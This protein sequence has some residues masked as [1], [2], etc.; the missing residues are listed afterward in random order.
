MRKVCRKI[1]LT[2]FWQRSNKITKVL[3]HEFQKSITYNFMW[4]AQSSDGKKSHEFIYI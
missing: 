4:C 3:K 1:C 2:Q